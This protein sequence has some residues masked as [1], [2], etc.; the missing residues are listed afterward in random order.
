MYEIKIRGATRSTYDNKDD[1]V[2]NYSESRKVPMDNC[3]IDT[4]KTFYD[5][6]IIAGCVCVS[7]ALLLGVIAFIIWRYV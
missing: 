3:S 6:G 7:F 4:G 2:G 1:I 5:V